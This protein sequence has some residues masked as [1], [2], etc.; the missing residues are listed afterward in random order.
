ML[1]TPP[2]AHMS[3]QELSNAGMFVMSTVGPPG[4]QGA[5]STGLQGMGVGTPIAAAVAAITIG[6]IGEVHM[7]KGGTFSMGTLSV[8][9]PAT[10]LLVNTGLG[11]ALKIEGATPKLHI[12]VALVQTCKG[13][14]F[15]LLS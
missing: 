10:M 14:C 6:F 5:G 11:V 7:P 15:P 12:M 9:T 3:L 4:T 2:Q 1:M 13:M 8:I